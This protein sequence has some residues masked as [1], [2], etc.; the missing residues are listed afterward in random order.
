MALLDKVF[1]SLNSNKGPS[2]S[3]VVGIDIGSSSIKVVEVQE[4]NS[5]LTLTTY[6]EIQLG[7]Y[8]NLDVG[9]MAVLDAEKEQSAL[10]DV[11]RES[12]VKAKMATFAMPLA[13]SFVTTMTIKAD[14]KEEISSRVRIEARKYIPVQ[15]SEVTL[16]WA[17]IET[18]SEV[19]KTARDVLLAAI[20]NDSLKRFTNL[21][22]FVHLKDTPTEIECF[23]SIR[24]VY[25]G[26]VKNVAVIDLGASYSRLYISNE[27]LL[28][29]MHRV[30]AGGKQVTDIV[31]KEKG[32]SFA[33]AEYMKRKIKTGDDGYDT[34]QK[35]YGSVY[36]R[37]LH[38]FRQVIE[39][40]E[41]RSGE[42][43]KLAYVC[44][45][46]SLFPGSKKQIKEALGREVIL[47][48]PFNKVAYPAFMEDAIRDLGPTFTTALGAAL[49]QFE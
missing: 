34:V 4:R 23:S 5:V 48:T 30:R 18:Q 12:A 28:Q 19:S 49:R 9:E 25:G 26:D 27:G 45:S 14:E 6:G 37:P 10:V 42:E 33:D 17:E 32:M 22:E 47:A 29:R 7:P 36:D 31:A 44:G 38:E 46:S 11:L 40:Y 2:S 39:E 1:S 43:V 20:Q 13:S 21:M 8:S 16:D 15:L 35:A 3:P 41:A 24:S